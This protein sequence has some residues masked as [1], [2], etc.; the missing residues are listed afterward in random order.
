VRGGELTSP[1]L[2]AALP[3]LHGLQIKLIWKP[4][5]V[6]DDGGDCVA[7]CGDGVERPGRGTL[8]RSIILFQGFHRRR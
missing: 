4:E 5:A 1:P 6:A 7:D 3:F 8:G 2:L